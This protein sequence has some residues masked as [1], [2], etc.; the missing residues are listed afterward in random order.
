MKPLWLWLKNVAA[1]L[2]TRAAKILNNFLSNQ[3]LDVCYPWAIIIRIQEWSAVT[4]HDKYKNVFHLVSQPLSFVLMLRN[5]FNT[6]SN[7]EKSAL[8]QN[9]NSFSI[10]TYSI[11]ALVEI[12]DRNKIQLKVSFNI[13]IIVVALSRQLV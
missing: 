8:D 11:P 12:S 13:L 7:S 2:L 10:L 1:N 4:L 6:S 5:I 9:D 3:T